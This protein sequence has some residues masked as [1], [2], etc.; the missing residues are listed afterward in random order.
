VTLTSALS[1]LG[2]RDRGCRRCSMARSHRFCG[3]LRD[4]E[5]DLDL[6]GVRQAWCPWRSR[7][8]KDL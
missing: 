7:A 8:W 5:G 6:E 3:S 2:H 1:E 4:S